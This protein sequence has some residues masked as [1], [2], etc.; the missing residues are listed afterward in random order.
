[1]HDRPDHVGAIKSA[2]LTSLAFYGHRRTWSATP[3]ILEQL[4]RLGHS[5]RNFVNFR[6]WGFDGLQ[7][8]CGRT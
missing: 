2:L 8:A 1:M 7:V 6:G 3:W 5:G 4:S